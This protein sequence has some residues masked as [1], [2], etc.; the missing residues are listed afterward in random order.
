MFTPIINPP[1]SAT[2]GIGRIVKKPWVVDDKIEIVSSMV[3]SLTFDHRIIDGAP[4]AQCLMTI[5]QYIENPY[6]AIGV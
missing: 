4:A 6:M 5:K 1:Q 2:L 3:L